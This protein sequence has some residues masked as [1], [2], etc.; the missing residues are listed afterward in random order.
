[1]ALLEKINHTK[2]TLEEQ[3]K[4]A[5]SLEGLASIRNTILGKKGLVADLVNEMRLLSAEEK[6]AFGK[7]LNELKDFCQDKIVT[8]EKKLS[9]LI[10]EQ[11]NFAARFLDVTSN[12][13]GDKIKGNLHIT[14]QFIA[15]IEDIFLSMGFRIFDGPEVENDW[16][17][18]GALNLPA[19]HPARDMYDTL[20]LDKP[21]HLLRTHTSPVQIR[22]MKEFGVPIAGIAP[23]RVFRHEATD[24]THEIIFSQCEGIVVDKNISM[25]HLIGTAK[26]F[27]SKFFETKNL[28]IRMRPGFF[29]FVEPGVEIDVRCVFCK[30]GCNVCKKTTWIEVF[31]GGMIHPNVLKAVNIDPNI[32]SGFAFGFGIDRL[33]MLM[34]AINDVRLFK[35]GDIRFIQQF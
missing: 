17:N 1:M 32:Y 11:K 21:N 33:A 31:P 22:A 20:W 24:A 13:P 25:A 10:F 12:L 5:N 7:Y 34:H 6:P 16:Y 9:K 2:A 30:S 4:T 35:S 18:F 3:L 14:N 26:T 27:L 19:D 8:Q 23:G 15:K 29:P 28:D